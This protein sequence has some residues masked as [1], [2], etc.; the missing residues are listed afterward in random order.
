MFKTANENGIVCLFTLS[1]DATIDEKRLYA[2]PSTLRKE[3]YQF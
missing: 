2:P 1:V 3:A